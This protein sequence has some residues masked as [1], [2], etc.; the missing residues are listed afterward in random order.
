MRP[1]GMMDSGVGG[2]TVLKAT[3]KLLPNER[4]IYVGDTARMP[5]GPRSSEEVVEFSLEIA[6]FLVDHYQIK[7]LAIACN[8][9]TACALPALQA[10]L[11]IPIVGV[12]DA[13][14]RAAIAATKNKRVGVIATE[15]TIS[16]GSY[17]G[18]LKAGDPDL[19][20]FAEAQPDFVQYVEG[21]RYNDEALQFEIDRHLANLAKDDVDTLVLGCTH[22]P[23]LAPL[24]QK[25]M[26]AN[27]TLVDPGWQ[28]ARDIQAIL[29]EQHL[30][31][32]TKKLGENIYY[33]TGS[34]DTFRV[35]ASD[36]MA[37]D[38]QLDI[39]H[40]VIKEDHGKGYLEEAK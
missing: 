35:I 34:P 2:L 17:Q 11:D 36:W 19:E 30:A 27:V 4:Y 10:E 7:L 23:L 28:T 25:S 21:A 37:S 39:R 40:L 3:Q 15:G 33:T 6:H 14:A 24:I 16:S 13:G 32:P 31:Q 9:A 8:T 38:K 5:Y 22:F 26:G 1:I 18:D 12:I 20:I 29:K